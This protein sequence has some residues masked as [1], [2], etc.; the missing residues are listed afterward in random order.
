MSKEN[1]ASLQAVHEVSRRDQ[2][3][4]KLRPEFEATWA[5]L[6]N[7]DAVPCL[8]VCFG[9]LLCAEQRLATQAAIGAAGGSSKIVNVA[10]A[11]QTRGKG[12][13]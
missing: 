12:T 5:G 1:L 2:F 11:A 13:M 9:E 6:L 3:L 7:R 4:M 8:D 10:Y